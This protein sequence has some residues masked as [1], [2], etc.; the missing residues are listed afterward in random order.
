[1]GIFYLSGGASSL[2][3]FDAGTLVRMGV[4]NDTFVRSGPDG[5]WSICGAVP[6]ISALLQVHMASASGQASWGRISPGPCD[7]PGLRRYSAVLWA[8]PESVAD[9]EAAARTLPATIS[10]HFFAAPAEIDRDGDV[11]T[12]HWLVPDPGCSPPDACNAAV[13][14]KQDSAV[15]P[16]HVGWGVCLGEDQWCFGAT[17]NAGMPVVEGFTNGA[18][19]AIGTREEMFAAFAAGKGGTARRPGWLYHKVKLLETPEPDPHRARTAA[20]ATRRAGFNINGNNS[21]THAVSV[22][23]VFAARPIVPIPDPRVPGLWT[24]S[25]WFRQIAGQQ[26]ALLE[27]L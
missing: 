23:N 16:G 21:M 4:R 3:P 15:H 22:L 11:V 1:M 13:F 20:E 25:Q 8:G 5:A 14:L 2:G 26:M 18:F 6:E 10:G 17:E 7:A 24:P 27:T 12:G 19:V 9:R